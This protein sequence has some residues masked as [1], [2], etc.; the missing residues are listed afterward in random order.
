MLSGVDSL[1]A[2]VAVDLSNLRTLLG[3]YVEQ[4]EKDSYKKT[5]PFG[6]SHNGR[7]R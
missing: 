5:F 2:M 1:H 6:G 4:F 7:R 3:I